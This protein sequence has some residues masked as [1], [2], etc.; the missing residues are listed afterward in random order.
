MNNYLK[1][2]GPALELLF[3][4]ILLQ[5][6]WVAFDLPN[7]NELLVVAQNFFRNYGLL[8]FFA[9]AAIE[10]LLLVGWYFPGGTVL[11]VGVILAGTNVPLVLLNGLI[12]SLGLLVAY[13]INYFIGYYGWYK[14][15]VQFGLG[16][17]V[18]KIQ[19][20]IADNSWAAFFL[21]YWHPSTAALSSTAAGL[22]KL[23][24]AKFIVNSVL[25]L[26]IWNLL[27]GTLIYFLG[28]RALGIASFKFVFVVIL[29]W[30][31][32]KLLYLYLSQKRLNPKI[33]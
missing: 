15:F 7:K 3:I 12:I 4:V 25:A 8:V 21:T 27:W 19:K 13:V 31:L 22:L 20:K 1:A 2:I 23:N 33:K 26:F 29:L 9:V 24:F 30:V 11:F 5:I 14:L 28:S 18:S 10:G 16:D 6:A 32:L 17:S